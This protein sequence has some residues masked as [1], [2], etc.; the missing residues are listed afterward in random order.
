MSSEDNEP[1][2]V[3]VLA[4]DGKGRNGAHVPRHEVLSPGLD[5]PPRIS[6]TEETST[7]DIDHE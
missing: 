7:K 5:T 3:F 4:P 1:I 2:A 6:P